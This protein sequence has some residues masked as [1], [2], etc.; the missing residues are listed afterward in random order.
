MAPPDPMTEEELHELSE[1]L[2][3]QCRD[4]DKR[5]AD[6]LSRESLLKSRLTDLTGR[7]QRLLSWESDL[8]DRESIISK[9]EISLEEREITL[10]QLEIAGRGINVTEKELAE[11]EAE[12]NAFAKELEDRR[13][14]LDNKE[15]EIENQARESADVFRQARTLEA[16]RYHERENSLKELKS[17]LD[18][19][20]NDLQARE[21]ALNQRETEIEA[22]SKE[23]QETAAG[24]T[25]M[26][27]EIKEAKKSEGKKLE[28]K[29]SEEPSAILLLKKEFTQLKGK[30]TKPVVVDSVTGNSNITVRDALSYVPTFNGSSSS[31]SDF[32][33]SCKRACSMLPTSSEFMFL[34]LL[35]QKF[36]SPARTTVENM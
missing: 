25:R 30:E 9:K 20:R 32:I 15:T 17:S 10:K 6:I 33:R 29:K 19:A 12:L 21:D 35:R 4:H 1:R 22:Q 24:L 27:R 11:R 8:K 13:A 2:E 16:E 5:E 36:K 28:T 31:V 26:I 23:L 3:A 34:T 14:E 18:Q 7:E